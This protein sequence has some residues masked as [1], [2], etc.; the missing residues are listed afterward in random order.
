MSNLLA[1]LKVNHA[2]IHSEVK[3]AMS[4]KVKTS[5]QKTTPAPVN[6]QPTLVESITKSQR[7]ERK[8]K[9][10]KELTDAVTYFVAKDCLPIYVHSREAWLQAI[11]ERF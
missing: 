1:H 2:K 10:W 6:S 4:N 9:K 8:G 11:T 5:V 3:A 7:Y